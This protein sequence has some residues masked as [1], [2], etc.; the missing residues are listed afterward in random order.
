MNVRL[1][2]TLTANQCASAIIAGLSL[3][4]VYKVEYEKVIDGHLCYKLV[5]GY[6]YLAYY[7]EEF[8]Q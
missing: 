8:K 6:I 4:S 7:F 1:K 3:N 2:T 5:G